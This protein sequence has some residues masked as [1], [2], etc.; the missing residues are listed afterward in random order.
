MIKTLRIIW[1][2]CAMLSLSGIWTPAAD[3]DPKELVRR[4]ETQYNGERSHA[5]MTMSITTGDWS[6]ELTMESWSEG[7]DKFL[8]VIRQPAKEQGTATLK[9]GDDIWN[10]LPRIDRLMKIPSSLMG[11]SWMGSH[12]TN[13]D[14]VKENKI[15]EL[16]TFAI[17]SSKGD[18]ASIVCTP[19]PDAA[20]VW[21]K[22][23]YRID[24]AKL[25]PVEVLYYDESGDLV[26]T[27]S[28]DQVRQVTGRWI[29]FRMTV[30][31]GD[32]P[33]ERTMI[34][35]SDLSFDIK[36]PADLFTVNSLRRQ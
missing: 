28:F 33:K 25:I 31:P 1:C 10:Y 19:R 30:K 26:R 14:L 15:D 13:D 36:L 27:M 4:V 29:P 16:Y 2:A 20:V 24:T 32:K 8:T 35:Y 18:T 22:I 9:I 7:R 6:R 12:L 11:D 17:Q 23:L 21:D 34:T 3:L 5:I